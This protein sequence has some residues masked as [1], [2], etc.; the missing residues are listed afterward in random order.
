MAFAAQVYNR[1]PK[2][3]NGYGSGLAPFTM[4]GL[5][6]GLER[7]VPFGNPCV[8]VQPFPE[9][10][11]LDNRR[12]RVL[13]LP[14]DTPGYI[15]LLDSPVGA[16]SVDPEDITSADVVPRRGGKPWGTDAVGRPSPVEGRPMFT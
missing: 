1:S 15:V 7:P 13:G 12:G 5:P 16:S 14:S 2:S 10:G 11:K 4:L 3:A 9:K 6:V 8:V